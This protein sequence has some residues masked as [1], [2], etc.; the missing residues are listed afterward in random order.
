MNLI[1]RLERMEFPDGSIFDVDLFAGDEAGDDDGPDDNVFATLVL[2]TNRD[3]CVA[4]FSPRR[5]EWSI[6]GGYREP[7]ESPRECAAREVT[8][9][10]SLVLDPAALT[11]C[12]QE[13]YSPIRVQGRWP[14]QGGVLRLFRVELAERLALQAVL[15]DAVDPCWI[16]VSAFRELAGERFWWPMMEA[17]LPADRPTHRSP[18]QTHDQEK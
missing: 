10:T 18:S 1:T 6:P 4:V 14:P 5:D 16:S 17:V 11:V 3:H 7:G 9:E 2:I 15:D 12:G 8:E 13:V